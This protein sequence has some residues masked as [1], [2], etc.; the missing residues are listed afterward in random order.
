MDNLE[1]WIIYK[2]IIITIKIN[3]S[4]IKMDN[5]NNNKWIIYQWIIIINGYSIKMD[6]NNK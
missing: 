3:G 5:N 6:N 4:Y 2:W 1:K